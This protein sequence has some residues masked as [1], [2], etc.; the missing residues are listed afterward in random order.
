MVTGGTRKI[1]GTT[2]QTHSLM[3]WAMDGYRWSVEEVARFAAS[4]I[5]VRLVLRPGHPLWVVASQTHVRQQ[6]GAEGE[7]SES[8]QH[9]GQ[10]ACP[11]AETVLCSG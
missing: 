5:G 1:T 6:G 10:G 2:C 11:A 7:A 9:A 8:D 3:P 4:D